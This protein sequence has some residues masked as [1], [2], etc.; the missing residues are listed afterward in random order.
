MQRFDPLD[1]RV[2]PIE[3]GFRHRQDLGLI[4]KGIV[5]K[6]DGPNRRNHVDARDQ[7]LLNEGGRDPTTSSEEENVMNTAMAAG[8]D[9]EGVSLT[10]SG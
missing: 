4:L 6:E 3:G 9:K 8:G 2:E 5:P 10:P 7:A 1:H